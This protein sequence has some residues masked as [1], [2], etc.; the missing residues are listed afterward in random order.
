MSYKFKL[1]AHEIVEILGGR[2]LARIQTRY[3]FVELVEI[4]GLGETIFIDGAPQISAADAAMF[5][6][7][8]AHA[9][10]CAIKN[11]GTIF[12]AGVASGG[13]VSELL[14]HPSVERV[15]A[16][17]LDREAMGFF[18]KNL[19]FANAEAL[20]DNRVNL[21]FADARDH[22][23]DTISDKTLDAII[24]D[25]PDPHATSPSR[26]LFTR[27]FYELAR[28]KLKRDGLLFTQSGRYR[29]GAMLYHRQIRAT[30]ME[31]FAQVKTYQFFYPCYYE[32]WSFLLCGN[33]GVCFPDERQVD[34]I[35]HDRN[36]KGLHYYSG[37]T[38]H[39]T[40]HIPPIFS[41]QTHEMTAPLLD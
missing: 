4:P 33:E 6:E 31:V 9:P 40:S 18:D 3:Q 29:I 2:S 39:A 20:S 22:L 32:P 7:L 27:Q 17:D 13:A 19:S 36:I 16:V 21:I 11:P 28:R 25:L 37:A 41:E 1:E 30:C 35:L 26:R 8:I 15:H 12:L 5:N 34:L 38:D 24:I 14:K 10:L 23:A